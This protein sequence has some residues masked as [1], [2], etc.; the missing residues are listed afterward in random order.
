MRSCGEGW[1]A[2]A[3]VQEET[4]PA[5]FSCVNEPDSSTALRSQLTSSRALE[6][7]LSEEREPTRSTFG[8]DDDAEERREENGTPMGV[9]KDC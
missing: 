9:G 2:G 3:E 1:V 6:S 4:F 7:T 8:T 5:S